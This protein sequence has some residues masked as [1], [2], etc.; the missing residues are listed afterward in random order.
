MQ[1][2]EH[3]D[4]T[5]VLLRYFENKSLREVG[6]ALGLERRRGSENGSAAAV[7]SMREFSR[8]ASS[9]ERHQRARQP[10]RFRQMQFKAAPCGLAATLATGTVLAAGRFPVQPA[11]PIA[12]TYCY[13]C[14]SKNHHSVT[15][16]GAVVAPLPGGARLQASAASA[17]PQSKNRT[18]KLC[19]NIKC[20]NCNASAT[21]RH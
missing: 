6:E 3:S 18:P 13:D 1:S 4:R 9:G 8:N 17:R 15:L 10:S 20:G 7:E 11:I 5:A 21:A 2:L 14:P 12:K 19:S 16:A